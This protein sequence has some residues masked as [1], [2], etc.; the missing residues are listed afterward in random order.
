MRGT[1]KN[2]DAF[3]GDPDSPLRRKKRKKWMRG[4]IPRIKSG[5]AHDGVGT[6]PFLL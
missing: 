4:S 6:T 1:P 3:F 2:A 5:D